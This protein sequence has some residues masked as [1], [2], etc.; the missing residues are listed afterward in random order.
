MAQFLFNRL[1]LSELSKKPLVVLPDSQP[2]CMWRTSTVE[3]PQQQP[4]FNFENVTY[5]E[6][7]FNPYLGVYKQQQP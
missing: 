6:D 5:V 7:P 2:V 3:V 4:L 1:Q